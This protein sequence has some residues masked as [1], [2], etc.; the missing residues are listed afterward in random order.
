LNLADE[1]KA[2]KLA[3]VDN[4]HIPFQSGAEVLDFQVS[5]NRKSRETT[6]RGNPEYK[7]PNS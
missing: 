3:D 5:G 2:L 6:G 1:L 7:L 4:C